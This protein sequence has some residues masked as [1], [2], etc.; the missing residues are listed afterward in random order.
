MCNFT[1]SMLFESVCNN[2]QLEVAKWLLSVNSNISPF[3]FHNR[4]IVNAYQ[5]KHI[6]VANWLHSMYPFNYY[7]INSKC[8]DKDHC[9]VNEDIEFIDEDIEFLLMMLY[10]LTNKCYYVHRPIFLSIV[11]LKLNVCDY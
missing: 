4:C 1:Y 9:F 3:Y 6:E 5:N 8:M 10:V 7:V 2:E 11:L